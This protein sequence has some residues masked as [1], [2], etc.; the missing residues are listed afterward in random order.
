MLTFVMMTVTHVS[1]INT[2]STKLRESLTEGILESLKEE[3]QD[4]W[5]F[6]LENASAGSIDCVVNVFFGIIRSQIPVYRGYY[7]HEL[8]KIESLEDVV[9]NTAILNSKID[10]TA[11]Q[12]K[13]DLQDVAK[14][15]GY[16]KIMYKKMYDQCLKRDQE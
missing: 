7:D 5:N 14:V 1:S 3:V 11:K 12:I 9:M 10:S 8:G 2:Y 13:D 4:F 16:Q 15:R 6:G